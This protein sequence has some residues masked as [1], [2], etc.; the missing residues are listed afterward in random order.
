M[1]M[2]DRSPQ[3]TNQIKLN[4]VSFKIYHQNVRSLRRKSQELLCHVYPVLPHVICLTE[5]HLNILEKSY[6][7]IEG[8]TIGAQFCRVSYEKGG[9]II[10][11]HNSLKFTNIDL[12][13]YCKEKDIEICAVKLITNSLN[14]CIITIYRAPTGN[15]N[16]F[17]QNV[18]NVLQFLYTPASYIIICGDLN[19]NYLVENEQKKQLDNL[20]LMYN[21]T[22]TVNFPVRINNTSASAIDNIFID[23]SHFEDFSVFPFLNDL[24]DHDAQILKIN[25]PLQMHSNKSKFIRKMDKHTIL[26]FTYN[27]SHET[28]DSAF[29]NNNDVNLMFNSFPNTYLRIF[30]SCFPFIRSKSRKH[31]NNW[32]I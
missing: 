30:Y 22:G 23:I 15:F 16:F 27:L 9:V 17:L 29:N 7:N 13:E 4:N 2:N 18:E 3:N 32:I 31:N 24:S 11:V 20:L 5:H 12:R 19:I 25:I 1:D 26:D 14:M 8:Y 21:L 28:W 10:Y 6:V